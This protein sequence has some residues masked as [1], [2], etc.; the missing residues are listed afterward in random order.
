MFALMCGLRDVSLRF[1][2]S[3][4]SWMLRY[5][6]IRAGSQNR[7][8]R[9]LIAHLPSLSCMA[10]ELSSILR[11]MEPRRS[12]VTGEGDV[13]HSVQILECALMRGRF[14]DFVASTSGEN[15]T[16]RPVRRPSP[17]R[18]KSALKFSWQ[19]RR[20]VVVVPSDRWPLL[21]VPRPYPRIVR[22]LSYFQEGILSCL[23]GGV[24]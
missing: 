7:N 19:E 16:R 11:L 22:Q 20:F 9:Y 10:G 3:I 14:W 24:S 15:R 8:N 13:D 1:S 2:D 17:R 6:T 12:D 23:R 18:E 4:S 21:F 5:R